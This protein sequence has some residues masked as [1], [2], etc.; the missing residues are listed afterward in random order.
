M[1]AVRRRGGG[2]VESGKAEEP[3]MKNDSPALR[4]TIRVAADMWLP[5]WR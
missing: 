2:Y 1:G 3:I 5:H 4:N